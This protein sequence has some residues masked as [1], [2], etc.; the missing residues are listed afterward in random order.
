[1]NES[2]RGRDRSYGGRDPRE[3]PAYSCAE[4]AH[5]A[6]VPAATLRS[7]VLG[8]PYKAAGADKWF[9]R[10]F[11]PA[12]LEPLRLSFL[13]LVEA[14][15]LAAI[16]R[17]YGVKM[18]RVRKALAFVERELSVERPLATQRF[19]TDGIDLFIEHAGFLIA[20]SRSGQH[21]SPELLRERL[22]RIEFDRS[23]LAAR[24]YPLARATEDAGQPRL[25]VIDPRIAYGRPSIAGRGVPTAVVA[26]RFY[27]GEDLDSLARDYDCS[28][29]QI[30]EAI[31][32]ERI[33]A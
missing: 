12:Q 28:R 33:A 23:G 3:L 27:A 30:S 22:R 17:E 13:N 25:I 7:W 18:P 19:Q 1:M 15:V 20:A 9:G 14:Y 5:L 29:E 32:C 6:H 4:A 16:R 2:Q 24:L 8:R 31:R 21:A 10:L 11:T 26:Q